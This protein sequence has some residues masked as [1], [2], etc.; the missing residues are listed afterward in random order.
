MIQKTLFEKICA[1]EIP[2]TMLHED[3]RCVAFRDISPQAPTH[4]LIIPRK[5]IPRVGLAEE[6]DEALLGHLLL[7]AGKVAQSEGIAES[8]YRLII[9]NGADGGEAV[10]HLH[11]HLLGGRQLTWPPG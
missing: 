1:K 4:I 5:P 9:N 2:A 10:P 6:E 7:V 3:D 8:G 11:V